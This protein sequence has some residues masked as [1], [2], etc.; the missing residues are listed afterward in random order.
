MTAT[1]G[2]H[3]DLRQPGAAD[4]VERESSRPDFLVLAYP[5]ISMMEPEVH[6]GSK[7]N[8][9]GEHPDAALV[10]SLSAERRV[11]RETPP[12][13]LFATTDD[14]VVPVRNSVLFYDALV[15]A[16]VPA[17]MHLF[18]HGSHG[19]GLAPKDPVLRMWPELLITWMRARGYAAATP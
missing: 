14:N 6:R 9:L 12:A 16:G 2:T 15:R 19:V 7:L 13:F 5:V 1:A 10:E 17:E 11:T 3:F 8:L 18:Q 4:A